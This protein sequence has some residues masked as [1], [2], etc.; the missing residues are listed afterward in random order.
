[1]SALEFLDPQELEIA[2]LSLD[3]TVVGDFFPDWEFQTL[4]GL[5]R[6]DV[7]AVAER[8]PENLCDP[9]T[10]TAV[11]NAL[12]N[13]HGYPHRL[14]GDLAKFGLAAETIKVVLDKLKNAET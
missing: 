10:E 5:S 13:L 2:K 7:R 1:M 9:V 11:F 12:T 8:W 3:A 14:E 6:E 4:F